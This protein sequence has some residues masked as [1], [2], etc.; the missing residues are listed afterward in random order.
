MLIRIFL[1]ILSIN[2]EKYRPASCFPNHCFCETITHGLIRQPVNAFTNLAYIIIGIYILIYIFHTRSNQQKTDHITGLPR[3]I[4]I[5][6]GL[7]SIAVG[8]GS[9]IYHAGFT[10]LGMEL[11]D[12]TMYLIGSFMLFWGLAHIQTINVKRFLFL[13]LSLNTGLE[14]LIYFFPVVRGFL[15][16]LLVLGSIL[17]D[18][19]IIKSQRTTSQI[20]YLVWGVGLFTLGYL[21][22]IPDYTKLICVPN[23]IIQGHAIWHVLTAIAILMIFFYMDSEYRQ[24]QK[25]G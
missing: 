1:W 12:D 5:L 11:D 19:L 14:L 6:F 9:F 4:F 16:G 7:A 15:F 17:I 13:Y 3:K 23:S 10:F 8:I 18:R 21:V 22:W 2:W 24:V 20:K 25:P